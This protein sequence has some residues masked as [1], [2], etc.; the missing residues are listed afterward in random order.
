MFSKVFPIDLQYTIYEDLG[1]GQRNLA[2]Q[3]EL[4]IPAGE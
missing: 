4:I 3:G 1:E 2:R